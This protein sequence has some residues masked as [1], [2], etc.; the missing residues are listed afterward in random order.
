MLRI[1]GT[2]VALIG[3]WAL[4]AL[5]PASAGA[6]AGATAGYADKSLG[7]EGFAQMRWQWDHRG[8]IGTTTD[9]NDNFFR[10]RRLRLRAT[11]DWNKY[12]R[13]RLQLALQE[14]AKGNVS[15]QVLEDAFVR[16]KRSDAIEFNFGQYKMPI[17]REELRSSSEQLVI[18]RSPIVNDNFARS[19]WISRDIGLMFNGNLYGHDVPIEYFFGAWN[20]EGRNRPADFRDPNDA[21]IFGGRVEYSFLPGFKIAASALGDPILGGGG[22]YTF[23]DSS[24]TIPSSRDY[25][26]MAKVWNVDG[27]FTRT[28][29][30]KRLVIEGEILQGTNTR[31][32]TNAM[33]AALRDTLSPA[34][35]KPSDEGFTQ[36]GMQVSGQLLFHTTAAPLTGWEIGTRMGQFDPNT[37]SDDNAI[38]EI[39][40]ALGLHFLDDP[41]INK[42]RL[43]F[44]YTNLNYELGTRDNDWSFKAQWQV[45]Y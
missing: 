14:L 18:D 27:N 17:S 28:T 40:V 2:L 11:A 24:F 6:G 9:E 38:T 1:R 15:G 13:V 37:G 12:F 7:I 16:I 21:K 5:F 34:L 8:A 10:L 30:G 20:G 35:P 4:T 33:A 39:A 23:G 43:Q 36:R 44:E 29:P 19:Q 41:E 45:R 31:V 26:E 32:F 22:K 42:D 25:S 3:I